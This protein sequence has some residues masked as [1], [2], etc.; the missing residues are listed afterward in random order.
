MTRYRFADCTLDISRRE[1]TRNGET[2]D[3][4]P[5]AFE[6]LHLLLRDYPGAVS[7]GD[8]YASLWPDT[9]VNLTNLNNVIAEIRAVIGDRAKTVILTKHRYGYAVGIPV[10][11]EREVPSRMTLIIGGRS[12]QLREGE[13]LVGRAP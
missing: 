2:V 9:I 7:R 3:V 6:A 5:R 12:I 1:L 8:L 4:S 13:N 11:V 10:A